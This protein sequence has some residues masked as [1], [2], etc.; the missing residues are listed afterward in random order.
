MAERRI[1]DWDINQEPLV[2]WTVDP[3]FHFATEAEALQAVSALG[4]ELRIAR[5][6]VRHTMRYLSVA[7]QTAHHGC[8]DGTRVAKLA[9]ASASGVARQTVYDM[10]SGE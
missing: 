5:E 10:L 8:E 3:R 7:M 6:Q 9:L 2:D 4:D 1:A